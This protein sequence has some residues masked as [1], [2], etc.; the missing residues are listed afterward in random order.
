MQHRQSIFITS[1]LRT[2]RYLLVIS[3]GGLYGQDPAAGA[4][5]DPRVEKIV[6]EGEA[7]PAAPEAGAVVKAPVD[8]LMDLDLEQC[9]AIARQKNRSLRTAENNLLSAIAGGRIAQADVFAPKLEVSH[10]FSEEDDRGEARAALNYLTPLGIEVSP[11]LSERVDSSQELERSSSVGIT[12]KRRVFSS[13][14]RWRLR[15]PLTNAERSVLQATNTLELRKREL[16]NS[17]MRAFLGVQ[18]VENRLRVRRNRVTDAKAFLKVTEERVATDLAP[19]VDIVNATINLNQAEADVLN[20]ETSL[21]SQTESLLNILGMGVTNDLHIVRYKLDGVVEDPF[22]LD[23]HSILLLVRHESLVNAQLNI[24]YAKVQIRIQQDRLRPQFDLSFTAEHRSEGADPLNDG[25]EEFDPLT[26]KLSY[27]TALDGKKRD[28]ARLKQLELDLEN[29]HSTL[30]DEE[31][32]LLLALRSAHRNISRLQTQVGLNKQRLEA[33]RA[34][35]VATIVRYE[36]GNVDNL[37]VTRAKQTVDNAEINLINT[38]IDLVL[39]QEDY[40]SLLPPPQ[41]VQ[42]KLTPP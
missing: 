27:T 38:N 34:K 24:D 9:R 41:P 29:L 37:E 40:Q 8:R 23:N 22:D 33:E 15:L 25:I 26:L 20:E 17:V 12:L 31:N 7:A 21:R 32:R 13:A 35:L 10:S 11:F 4:K 14:E 5:V 1:W 36:D 30:V 18:R 2:A 39:A 19:R 6:V 42:T 3:A 16:D 28:K